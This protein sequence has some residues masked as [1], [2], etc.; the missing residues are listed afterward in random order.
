V[1]K[2]TYYKLGQRPKQGIIMEKKIQAK[3]VRS[4]QNKNLALY[5]ATTY[6]DTKKGYQV[7]TKATAMAAGLA[8]VTIAGSKWAVL[9]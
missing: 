3:I 5:N 6:F 2:E 8:I 1:N 7:M 4:L 9:A